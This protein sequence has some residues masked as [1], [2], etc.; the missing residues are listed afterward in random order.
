[1]YQASPAVCKQTSQSIT[2]A[3]VASAAASIRATVT[4]LYRGVLLLTFTDYAPLCLIVE[5]AQVHYTP[6]CITL[7]SA[8]SVCYSA[9]YR[10]S[11]NVKL[12]SRLLQYRAAVPL[13]LAVSLQHANSVAVSVI[14]D[15]R[16]SAAVI[17][18]RLFTLGCL[19]CIT[20]RSNRTVS[21]TNY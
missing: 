19:R 17:S 16:C 10:A 20:L 7:V 5:G 1:V 14:P 4:D 13:A 18:K 3:T 12:C 11:T 6:H 8:L 2:P 15:C 9:C 21:A